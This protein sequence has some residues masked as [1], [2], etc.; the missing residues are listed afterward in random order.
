MTEFDSVQQELLE[1]RQVL[2][3]ILHKINADT[4]VAA[5]RTE[6]K[7]LE[8]K[9]KNQIKGILVNNKHMFELSD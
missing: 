5:V 4:A 1:I 3:Q 8:Q 9:R 7:I 6:K 2:N